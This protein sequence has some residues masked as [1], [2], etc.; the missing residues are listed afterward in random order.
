MSKPAVETEAAAPNTSE[1]SEQDT[2]ASGD[3]RWTR[4]FGPPETGQLPIQQYDAAA[5]A[6][7]PSEPEF[8]DR[9]QRSHSSH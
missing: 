3:S 2:T 7:T 4:T 5:A 9:R 6:V 1:T 8:T